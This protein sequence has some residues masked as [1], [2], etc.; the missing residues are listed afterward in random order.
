MRRGTTASLYEHALLRAA[1]NHEP[2]ALEELL[3]R[4]E[5]LIGAIL[6]RL[7]LPCGCD[8]S[9]IAQ[10]ARLGLV[11]AISACQPARGPFPALAARCARGQALNALDTAGA[12]KHQ[13]LSHAQSLES[14]E[15]RRRPWRLHDPVPPQL[16]M[17]EPG[18][19]LFGIPLG[20]Q[21]A[22]PSG[23]ADPVSVLLAREHLECVL[24]AL[25]SLT[26]KERTVLAGVLNDKSHQQVAD[27][28]GSTRKAVSTA[29]RR[30]RK[31]LAR[32]GTL[33]A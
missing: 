17:S 31:K 27:E 11:R 3:R 2:R 6:A 16:T 1:Q 33:A 28:H 25:P 19:S 24:A 9:D 23:D 7:R 18:E 29:L 21:L 13:L 15:P 22:S 14:R 4:Y 26:A 5:P 30:A 12:H 8:A 32:P 20:E 10:E